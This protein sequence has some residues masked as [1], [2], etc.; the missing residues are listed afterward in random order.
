MKMKKAEEMM[1]GAEKN[2]RDG[3]N[4]TAK[5]VVAAIC[6]ILATMTGCASHNAARRA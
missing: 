2:M 5:M 1:A 3:G 6:L 4:I